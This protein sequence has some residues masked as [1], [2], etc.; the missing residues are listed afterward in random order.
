MVLDTETCDSTGNVYD[1]GYA[2]CTKEGEILHTF[3]AP[4]QVGQFAIVKFKILYAMIH[5]FV[6]RPT[7]DDLDITIRRIIVSFVRSRTKTKT[8]RNQ[9]RTSGS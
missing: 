4:G 8:K 9:K 2:I 7:C 1:V 3:N 5:D 6:N